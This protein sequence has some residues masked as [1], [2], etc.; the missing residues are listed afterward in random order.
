[1]IKLFLFILSTTLLFSSSIENK[2]TIQ[3]QKEN[4]LIMIEVT[5]KYCYYC[6]KMD[7]NVF[8]DKTVLSIL[9]KYYIFDKIY[10]DKEKL[11]F[12]LK[13]NFSGMTPT[14]FILTKDGT[15]LKEIKG[16]WSKSDFIEILNS[17]SDLK[18]D[19]FDEI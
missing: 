6:K 16:S 17:N 18:E 3:A 1:M 13:E 9:N 14:F 10:I 8:T 15:F 2:L 11:P 7:N 5:S 12:N 19:E 4:K